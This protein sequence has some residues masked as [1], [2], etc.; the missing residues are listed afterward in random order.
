[1]R[2]TSASDNHGCTKQQHHKIVYKTSETLIRI[3]EPLTQASG[4]SDKVNSGELGNQMKRGLPRTV[5]GSHS[6]L[7][8]NYIVYV[9]NSYT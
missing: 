6:R 8:F 5:G 7:I 3:P 2:R 9:R 1:M 4:S